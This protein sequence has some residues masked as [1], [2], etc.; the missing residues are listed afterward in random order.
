MGRAPRAPAR[1]AGRG[2]AATPARPRGRP[3]PGAVG[4]VSAATVLAWPG[5][6]RTRGSPRAAPVS[7]RPLRA[8]SRASRPPPS[9]RLDA[10]GE[11][12]PEHGRRRRSAS[13]RR[14]GARRRGRCG[15]APRPS[16]GAPARVVAAAASGTIRTDPGREVGRRAVGERD[17]LGRLGRDRLEA[18]VARAD[19][20]EDEG[21]ARDAGQGDRPPHPARGAAARS[22]LRRAVG[23]DAV[24]GGATRRP[25][26]RSVRAGTSATGAAVVTATSAGAR[27]PNRPRRARNASASAV[28]RSATAARPGWR[29]RAASRAGGPHRGGRARRA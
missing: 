18:R 2:P 6:R 20:R 22:R 10:D 25:S 1:R 28:A 4:A 11:D 7:T 8:A 12:G 5:A 27:R 24:R 26:G 15:R 29:A 14:T 17:R 16:A 13:R 19:R 3:R 9:R 21:E 23:G